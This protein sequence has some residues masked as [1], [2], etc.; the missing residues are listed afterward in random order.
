MLLCVALCVC[1]VDDCVLCVCFLREVFRSPNGCGERR[2]DGCLLW[3]ACGG[4]CSVYV[5]DDCVLVV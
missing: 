3:A 2:C 5:A 1:V 4:V